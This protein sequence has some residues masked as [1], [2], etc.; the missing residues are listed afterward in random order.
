MLEVAKKSIIRFDL[1]E[2]IIKQRQNK[3]I[4]K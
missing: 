1:T 2:T 3:I 4:K